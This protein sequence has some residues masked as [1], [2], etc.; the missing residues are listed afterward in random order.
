MTQIK[1]IKIYDNFLSK[2]YLNHL[3]GIFIWSEMVDYRICLTSS[4]EKE[5]LDKN[6]FDTQVVCELIR[7]PYFVSPNAQV[8]TPFVDVIPCLYR[9]KV[10]VTFPSE[11]KPVRL[12]THT[13]ISHLDGK[14]EYYSGVFYLNGTDGHTEITNPKTKK[15]EIVE[16]KENRLVVFPGNWKH[17]GFTPTNTKARYIFNFV[18]FGDFNPNAIKKSEIN[19]MMHNQ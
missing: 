2:E 4:G 16:G 14:H 6:V 11:N 1:D 13:D 12:G 8:L 19:Y 18:F 5:S 3:Q 9:A 7:S 15:T 10:N 17:S